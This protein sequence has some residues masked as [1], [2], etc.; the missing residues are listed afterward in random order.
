MQQNK[1][2]KIQ[3]IKDDKQF[4]ADDDD[5]PLSLTSLHYSQ[6]STAFFAIENISFPSLC[7]LVFHSLTSLQCDSERWGR[8]LGIISGGRTVKYRVSSQLVLGVI[9]I[10]L[11]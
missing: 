2:R 5:N 4:D 9:N 10:Y 3:R 6:L 7:G 8:C 11:N 1:A